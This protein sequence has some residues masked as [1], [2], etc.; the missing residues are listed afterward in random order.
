MR[1]LEEIFELQ[2]QLQER[3]HRPVQEAHI[4]LGPA[5]KGSDIARTQL[6]NMIRADVE[7]IRQELAE[8]TDCFPWKHWRAPCSQPFDIQNAKV[9]VV[10]IL[11]FLVNIALYLGMD[12]SQLHAA[13][14]AK[15][16]VNHSRQDSG[17]VCK[18]PDDC[19]HIGT[20]A[21]K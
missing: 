7:A 15:N 18:D 10:D 9:E 14:T 6:W 8:L 16:K 21:E 4:L 20:G 1:K 5:E 17:Y 12:A 3:L 13:F 19:R 2:K 11:H